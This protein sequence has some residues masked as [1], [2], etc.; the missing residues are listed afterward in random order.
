MKNRIVAALF[1]LFLGS[2]GVHKF[3][4]RDAGAGIFYL[5][6]MMVGASMKLPISM[7]LGWVD[8]LVLFTMS[9][10]KFD[11]KYNKQYEQRADRRNQRGRNRYESRS[12]GRR[13]SKLTT[14]PK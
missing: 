8:A 6:L 7:F 3:Y 4:L 2:F 11:A 5:I 12:Q 9:D 1:A 10:E 14:C 13:Y